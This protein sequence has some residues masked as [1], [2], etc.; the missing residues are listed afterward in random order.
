MLLGDVLGPPSRLEREVTDVWKNGHFGY[1]QNMTR[2]RKKIR[3]K[4]R[5]VKRRKKKKIK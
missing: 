3:K 4:N 1:G 2:K 5:K